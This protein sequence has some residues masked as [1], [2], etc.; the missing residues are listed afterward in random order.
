MRIVITSATSGWGRNFDPGQ[1]FGIAPTGEDTVT[2]AQAEVLVA[3]GRAEV[4]PEP[5]PAAGTEAASAPPDTERPSLAVAGL[6]R[7]RTAA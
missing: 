7:K 2:Y 4:V 5:E 6:R 1:S 3:N